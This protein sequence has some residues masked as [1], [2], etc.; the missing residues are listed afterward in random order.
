MVREKACL[1]LAYIHLRF[2]H[3][4]MVRESLNRVQ[5]DHPNFNSGP[6]GWAILAKPPLSTP[7]YL[8]LESE[9]WAILAKLP[10]NTPSDL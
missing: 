10:L 4:P 6:G 2:Q 7:S 1:A 9:G 5:T 8:Q 3:N